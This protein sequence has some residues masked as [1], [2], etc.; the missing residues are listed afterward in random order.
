MSALLLLVSICAG[1]ALLA[2]APVT[3]VLILW[4]GLAGAISIVFGAASLL[5]DHPGADREGSD[6]S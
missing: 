1:V 5:G 3:A 4:L 2:D 6:A